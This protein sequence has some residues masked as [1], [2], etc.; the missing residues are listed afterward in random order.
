MIYRGRNTICF[1]DTEIILGAASDSVLMANKMWLAQAVS[2]AWM[3][4][5]CRIYK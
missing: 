3:Y 4:E 1:V 2:H 5:R